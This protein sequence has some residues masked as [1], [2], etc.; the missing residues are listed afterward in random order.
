MGRLLYIGGICAFAVAACSAP[1]K[2]ALRP[3]YYAIAY[4]RAGVERRIV[5]TAGSR[6]ASYDVWRVSK[7][8]NGTAVH[9]HFDLVA[10][11]DVPSSGTFAVTQD[12][13]DC[14]TLSIEPYARPRSN[15][16][17]IEV[18]R[19]LLGVEHFVL[20]SRDTDPTST[21]IY[22]E[23]LNREIVRLAASRPRLYGRLPFFY[24]FV[25]G[26]LTPECE[27]D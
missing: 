6:R 1:P 15:I 19:G 9:A 14:G 2:H 25:Y 13:T 26:E 17:A 21:S 5:I 20:D 16:A 10:P 3:G 8:G 7:S 12:G 18:R 4:I 22:D 11:D 27:Y 24:K 23:Q